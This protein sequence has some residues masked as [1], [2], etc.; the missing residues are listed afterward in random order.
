MVQGSGRSAMAMVLSCGIAVAGWFIG[1][2][3]VKSRT[4]DR[5][6]TVKGVSERD[7]SG[8]IA[9]WPIHFVATDDD[10][11]AAR[12]A[13]RRSESSVLAFLDRHGIGAA[14]VAVQAIQVS[15]ALANPFRSGPVASRYTITETLMVRTPDTEGVRRAGR[16]VGELIDAGVVLS[17]QHGPQSGPTYLFT[18]LSQV[19]PE[20][21]AEATSRAREAAEKF[22]A[23]SGSEIAGIK[24]ANQGVFVVLP[25]DRAAGVIQEHSLEKTVRVVTTI[26]YLLD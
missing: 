5:H 24:R 2:G 1:D 10:L 26:D 12:A 20:M 8:D 17:S 9:L 3:F 18:R 6:V 25:R 23:D 16:S 22:A 13:I 21:I 7:V 15:D 11:A 19:K 14:H 4:A